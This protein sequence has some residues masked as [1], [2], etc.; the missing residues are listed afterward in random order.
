[1][2]IVSSCEGKLNDK[3]KAFI[4]ENFYENGV[5]SKFENKVNKMF[6]EVA[7]SVNVDNLKDITSL[8][9]MHW[10][11]VMVKS[12]FGYNIRKIKVN[13]KNIVK[14]YFLE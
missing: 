1:M 11:I 8:H 12:Y 10:L 4:V 5:K 9:M 13:K 6:H 3:H 14:S 7:Q 2:S